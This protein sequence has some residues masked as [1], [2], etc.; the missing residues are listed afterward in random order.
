MGMSLIQLLYHSL[1]HNF[2]SDI[3]LKALGAHCTVVY[4]TFTVHGLIGRGFE[5]RKAHTTNHHVA[6]VLVRPTRSGERKGYITLKP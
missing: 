1:V 6:G 5:I 3:I 2:I 4:V